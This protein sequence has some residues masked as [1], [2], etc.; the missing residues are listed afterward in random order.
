MGRLSGVDGTQMCR[1]DHWLLQLVKSSLMYDCRLRFEICFK[2][3]GK[4]SC[5]SPESFD[6]LLV[7]STQ[8][9]KMTNFMDGGRRRP[10]LQ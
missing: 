5:Y 1:L 4:R 8:P 10:N 6:K 2:H 3:R 9:D 7:K